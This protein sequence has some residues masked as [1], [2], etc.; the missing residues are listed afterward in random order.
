MLYFCIKNWMKRKDDFVEEMRKK[1]Y[2]WKRRKP[3]PKVQKRA[4]QPKAQEPNSVS[5]PLSAKCRSLVL[6]RVASKLPAASRRAAEPSH[7]AHPSRVAISPLRQRRSTPASDGPRVAHPHSARCHSPTGASRRAWVRRFCLPL[8]DV[9]AE[10]SS[11]CHVS[12]VAEKETNKKPP[13]VPVSPDF[14]ATFPLFCT[15]FL[16][17]VLYK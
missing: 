9:M 2:S 14:S 11:A 3:S 8:S 1:W 6:P 16:P 5:L 15:R 10:S 7:E 17:K 4:Q 13:R 12:Q